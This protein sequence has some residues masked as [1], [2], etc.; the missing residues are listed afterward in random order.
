MCGEM[1]SIHAGMKLHSIEKAAVRFCEQ[2]ITGCIFPEMHEL[3]LRLKAAGC[4]IWAVSSTNE[5]VIREGVMQYGIASEKVLA[6]SVICENGLA[7]DRILRVPTGPG[8][9][10][11]IRE[12]IGR[13]V[14]AVFGNSMHDLA[15]LELARNPVV[16]NPTPDLQLI[17]EGRGWPVYRPQSLARTADK[18]SMA[19]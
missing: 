19:K 7:T 10:R 9:A 2:V 13:D 6:A 1:V 14:D 17:A 15:M 11:A 4:E 3:A 16:I 5:W 8:K 18:T 12:M